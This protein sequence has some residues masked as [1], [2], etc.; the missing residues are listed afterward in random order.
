[1]AEVQHNMH[2]AAIYIIAK[3]E[4]KQQIELTKNADRG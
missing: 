3:V 2:W 4:V 1:L